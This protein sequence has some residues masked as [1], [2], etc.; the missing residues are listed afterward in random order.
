MSSPIDSR[1]EVRQLANPNPLLLVVY[2][3]IIDGGT[4]RATEYGLR[5][6]AAHAQRESLLSVQ[7]GAR[8]DGID[9]IYGNVGSLESATYGF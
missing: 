2:S 7:S 1:W 9:G 6:T 5:L 3:R 4:Q 8:R